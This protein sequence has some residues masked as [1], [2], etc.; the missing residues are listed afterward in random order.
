MKPCTFARHCQIFGCT[1]GPEDLFI[2]DMVQGG[3]RSPRHVKR[4]EP[5]HLDGVAA[6]PVSWAAMKP[7]PACSSVHQVRTIPVINYCS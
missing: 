2:L 1:I 6:I 7:N 3:L 5:P 4:R